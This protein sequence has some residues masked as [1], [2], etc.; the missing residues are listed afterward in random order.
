MI[1]AV[2]QS[3]HVDVARP[4]LAHEDP[5]VRAQTAIVLGNIG[6]ASDGLALAHA[7]GDESPWVA[8]HA[9]AALRRLGQDATLRI[10]KDAPETNSEAAFEA[11]AEAVSQ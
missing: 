3:K 7:V 11:L 10:L 4:L 5:V 8:I 1:G 6:D 2:G 9:A